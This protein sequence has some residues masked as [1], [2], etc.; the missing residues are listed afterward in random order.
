[1]AGRAAA[2]AV[3]QAIR[4]RAAGRRPGQRGLRRRPQ[5]ERVPGGAGG[6]Q[7]HRLVAGG[8]LPHGR[9]PRD[10]TADHPASFRRYLQEHLFRLVGLDPG[11]APAD[12]RRAE[13]T[14]RCGPAWLTRSSCWPSRSTSSAPGSARTAISPSTTRPSPTSS[15]PCWSRSSASTRPAA[16]QQLHDGCFEQHR[17]GP[18]P[19]LHADDPRPADGARSSSVVV[20]GPRKA[21][22][23]LTTLRGPISEACPATALRRHP[24][25]TLYLDRDAARLVL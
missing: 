21:N 5:P 11:R 17:G 10:L 14:G 22:A 20:P 15:T 8:R 19:R 24:G 18:D 6:E 16:H 1:M 9:I 23:V 2:L 7:G 12:P 25:A 4:R 13:P 3:A